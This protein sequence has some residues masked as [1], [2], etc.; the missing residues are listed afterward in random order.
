MALMDVLKGKISIKIFYKI[1]DL[2]R[3]SNGLVWRRG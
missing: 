3:I 2:A 1:N